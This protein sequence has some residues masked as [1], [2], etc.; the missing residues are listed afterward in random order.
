MN[1]NINTCQY[2]RR[3]GGREGGREGERKRRE[4]GRVVRISRGR[5]RD[6]GEG[7]RR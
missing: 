6:G 4:R 5:G 7:A 2:T 3:E 1:L